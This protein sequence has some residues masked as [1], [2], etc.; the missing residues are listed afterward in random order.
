MHGTIVVKEAIVKEHPWVAGS[1]FRA[2]EQ[3]KG[4]W[5]AGL[6][7]GTTIAAGDKKY[8]DLMKVVGDDPLPNGIKANGPTIH[9]L[10]SY[11]FKQSLTPRRMS[12]GELFVDPQV[13]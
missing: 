12:V 4:E 13:E 9:A 8:L 3:A 11:A 10:E 2:F 7:S 6:R 1:L 5:L